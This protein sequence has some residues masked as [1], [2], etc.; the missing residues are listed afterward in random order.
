MP[1]ILGIDTGGTN[2]DGVI[3]DCESKKALH[4]AKA[5]TTKE[6]LVTGIKEC[7]DNIGISDYSKVKLVSLS[8]TLAT[9]AVVEGKTR[10]A[11]LLIIGCA[12]DGKL[13][14]HQFFELRG[15]V[16]IKGNVTEELDLEQCRN[17]IKSFK[18]KVEAV[19]VSGF[20][21]VRNPELELKVKEM[22]KELLGVPVVCGH[23]LSNVLGFYERT[24]TAALNAQLIPIIKE[25][26]DAV[27]KALS[28]KNIAA[29]LF[30]VKGDGTLMSTA[31]AEERPVETI[32]SG[33]A[34]SV[35]GA[36][37][38]SGR[39]KDGIVFD[40][41][42]TTSDIAIMENGAIKVKKEGATVGGWRTRVKAGDI[43]TYGAGG[44]SYLLFERPDK[45]LVGPG[46]VIPLCVAGEAYPELEE[47]LCERRK[48]MSYQNTEFQNCDCF[49]MTS[50]PCPEPDSTEKAIIDLL[51]EKPRSFISLTKELKSIY[52]IHTLKHLVSTGVIAL[53]SLTPTDVLHL[54]GELCLW[55]KNVSGAGVRVLSET[56]G[57]S[58]DVLVSKAKE[59]VIEK[60][61]MICV[62]SIASYEGKTLDFE[63]SPEAQFLLKRVFDKTG[64]RYLKTELFL[65]KPVIGIGAPAE[66]WIKKA[67]D[68]LHGKFILP[69]HADVASAAGAAAGQI[70]EIMEALIR[71]GNDDAGYALFLPWERKVLY[72]F[73]E[74]LSYASF[75]MKS[76]LKEK[77]EKAGCRDYKLL[78]TCEHTEAD[79][80]SGKVYIETKLQS[81]AMGSPSWD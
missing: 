43:Y 75:S 55:N 21:S 23:E 22:V 71:P 6:N 8:T 73:D 9:N 26:I 53:S 24:V 29:P 76:R 54:S 72:D 60:L 16:D 42:G 49:I 28:E 36:A 32:L 64:A 48:N 31:V 14:V 37:F 13:P 10:A 79:T 59:A 5:P 57:V 4:T 78:E 33:P 44:D 63:G 3:I 20:A 15:A 70:I 68:K 40:M 17:N 47:E 11:G 25:I 50:A 12:P 45:I 7:I 38:L 58:S 30:I 1:Y 77:M 2:T 51:K 18:G 34:A 67:A 56:F 80:N 61:S 65:S 19:A 46:R 41:G 52:I 39:I 81:A 35:V 27:K 62:N 74:A 69:K 66:K